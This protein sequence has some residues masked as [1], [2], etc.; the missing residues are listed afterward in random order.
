MSAYRPLLVAVLWL[1]V[2]VGAVARPA[3]LPSPRSAILFVGAGT[4]SP[5]L[6]AA[7]AYK[8][9]DTGVAVARLN[10]D[11]LPVRAAVDNHGADPDTALATGQ[12][13]PVAPGGK[14][15]PT[16]LEQ[17]QAQGRS[18]GLV[19]TV[20]VVGPLLAGF[21]APLVERNDR[22]A[23]AAQY[24]DAAP[25]V[26]VMLGGGRSWFL[27]KAAPSTAGGGEPPE[28][29]RRADHRNL[30][31]EL[32][33]KRYV[34]LTDRE[35][36]LADPGSPRLVGLFES[37][38][39]SYEIDRNVKREPSLAEMTEAALR[40][41]SRNPKGF[42]LVVEGGRIGWAGQSNDLAT[43][44]RET[45]ALDD[46]VGVALDYQKTHP[47]TLIVVTGDREIGG[48]TFP[49]GFEP[50]ALKLQQASVEHV[51]ESIP[52]A[53]I[54]PNKPVFLT[55]LRERLGLDPDVPLREKLKLAQRS[56]RDV[57]YLL[58][59]ALSARAHA[60]WSTPGATALP[61]FLAARGP[62]QWLFTG[63]YPTVDIYARL[64][65]FLGIAGD[66]GASGANKAG[67]GKTK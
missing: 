26:D 55:A 19:T 43:L 64:A 47:D 8:G 36:L 15:V 3:A 5:Q 31:D 44:A 24:V 22:A 61:P 37:G 29:G 11:A 40:S 42:L 65:R 48:L 49:A 28:K 46:A 33:A 4:A 53:D 9:V 30:L 27:P 56:P 50:A 12:R 57:L 6:Y 32:K 17:A 60:A 67:G 41:L 16:L 1:A 14:P 66:R 23:I 7:R 51:L 21:A 25:R 10:I 63:S 52:P 35:G 20:S 34:V 54:D 58:T 13:G 18:S 59:G 62:Q 39:L 38:P 45:L 2:V